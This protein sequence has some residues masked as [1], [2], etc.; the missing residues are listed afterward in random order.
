M[1]DPASLLVQAR[2][3]MAFSERDSV[4]GVL[5]RC[6]ITVLAF[7]LIP[8]VADD[9]EAVDTVFSALGNNDECAG[10]GKTMDCALHAMQFQRKIVQPP[11]PVFASDFCSGKE[12]GGYCYGDT[13]ITC[14]GSQIAKTRECTLASRGPKD[15]SFCVVDVAHGSSPRAR[16]ELLPYLFSDVVKKLCAGKRMGNY[17][18]GDI[19]VTCSGEQVYQTEFCNITSSWRC[20][21]DTTGSYFNAHC[22][23]RPR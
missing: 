6:L 2:A 12:P 20:I 10:D 17:C 13:L 14:D 7:A 23:P 11:I 9:S 8:A 22:G 19:L 4:H 3:G 21:V 15:K 18:H 1:E 5:S 16:C